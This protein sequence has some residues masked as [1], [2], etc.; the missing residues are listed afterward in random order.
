LWRAEAA[1]DVAVVVVVVVVVVGG[2][3]VVVG[4]GAT[5]APDARCQRGCPLFRTYFQIS[6]E[7]QFNILQLPQ[8]FALLL[9][10]FRV[11]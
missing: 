4:G 5:M 7:T 6:T 3:V 1:V 11:R 9:R 2:G 8:L 10:A